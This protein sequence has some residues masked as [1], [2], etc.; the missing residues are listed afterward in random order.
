[1]HFPSGLAHRLASVQRRWPFVFISIVCADG[2]NRTKEDEFPG[3]AQGSFGIGS[4]PASDAANGALALGIAGR[5]VQP[6]GSFA[7]RRVRRGDM[8]NS[9]RSGALLIFF[10]C[11][12]PSQTRFNRTQQ[13]PRWLL[14]KVEA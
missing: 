8:P 3:S 12:V 2:R 13:Y 9:A 6:K 14:H 1:M 4:A 5:D 7:V 11:I 10:D